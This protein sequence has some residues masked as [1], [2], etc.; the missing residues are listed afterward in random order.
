MRNPSTRTRRRNLSINTNEAC[1][2]RGHRKAKEEKEEIEPKSG[3]VIRRL[4][5]RAIKLDPD[6]YPLPQRRRPPVRKQ[7]ELL[8]AGQK[9]PPLKVMKVEAPGADIKGTYILVDGYAALRAY[10][11]RAKDYKTGKLT[12]NLPQVELEA[13]HVEIVDAPEDRRVRSHLKSRIR[14]FY[15]E[16][17]GCSERQVARELRCDIKTVKKCAADLIEQWKTE[18]MKT[19]RRMIS[20]RMPSRVIA[21]RLR[22]KWPSARGLSQPVISRMIRIDRLKPGS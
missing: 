4:P 10:Q 7:L 6:A 16:F 3:P 13:I 14:E 12:G 2:F 18:K 5:L 22:Q 8:L 15:Q 11:R 19:I 17:P 1:T 9:L 20:I 21:C